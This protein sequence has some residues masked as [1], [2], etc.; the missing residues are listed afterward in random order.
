M[1]TPSA[2][3][4]AYRDPIGWPLLPLPVNGQLT[5]PSLDRGVRDSIRVL[6]LTRPG[7]QLMRP[8]FGAGLDNFRGLGNTLAT[9]R[10]IQSVIVDTLS[11]YEPRITVDRV[12]V[13]P[14]PT[15]PTEIHVQ[16]HYRLVRTGQAQQVGATLQAG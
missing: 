6:L 15:A 9:R 10:R 5:Y 11:A 8:R 7:E 3:N 12:D 14:I 13:D 4:P 2:P 16:I 1:A